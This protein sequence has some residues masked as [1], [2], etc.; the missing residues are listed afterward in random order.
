[1]LWIEWDCWNSPE[2]QNMWA[3]DKKNEGFTI[4]VDI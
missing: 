1:M 3:Y 2:K 4:M